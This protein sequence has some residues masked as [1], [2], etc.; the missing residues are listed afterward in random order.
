[1]AARSS[2][3]SKSA[4]RTLVIT[5]VLDAPP[6]L[7]FKAWTDPKHAARWWGPKGFTTTY[8]KLDVRPGGKWRICMRSPQGKDYWAQGVY[9]E[10]VEPERLVFTWAWEKPKGRPGRETLVRVNFA[11]LGEKTKLTFRHGVFETVKDRNSHRSG[12]SQSLDRL[13]EYIAK[14]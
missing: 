11:E 5:R 7:V 1:M 4:S 6:S 13:A 3:G 2:A 8:C 9:R 12:W 14:G 10:I